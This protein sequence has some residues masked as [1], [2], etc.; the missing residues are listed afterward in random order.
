MGLS[1]FIIASLQVLGGAARPHVPAPEQ[2][3][4]A[5]WH[6]QGMGISTSFDRSC[7]VGMWVLADVCRNQAVRKQVWNA[8]NPDLFRHCAS[9]DWRRLLQAT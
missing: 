2:D 9:I 8:R 6:S 5:I 3:K 1:M 4:T 7:I